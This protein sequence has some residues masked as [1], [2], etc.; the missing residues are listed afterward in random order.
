MVQFQELSVL[1]PC[2]LHSFQWD[3]DRTRWV[4]VLLPIPTGILPTF[5]ME[6]YILP[7]DT[8]RLWKPGFSPPNPAL[9]MSKSSNHLIGTA[10][11]EGQRW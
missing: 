9:P 10:I 6:Q 11:W 5:T 7:V 1:N 4:M 3:G 8:D 2:A